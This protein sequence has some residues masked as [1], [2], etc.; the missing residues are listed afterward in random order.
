[1]REIFMPEIGKR[2]ELSVPEFQAMNKAANEQGLQASILNIKVL[3]DGKII[4]C[5]YVRKDALQ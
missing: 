1:M 4:S 5:E 2:Y 3:P